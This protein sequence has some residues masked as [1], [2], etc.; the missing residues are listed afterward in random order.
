VHYRATI[1]KIS[2]SEGSWTTQLNALLEAIHYSFLKFCIYSFS[3]WYEF[4]VY[5]A[6]RV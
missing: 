3:L 4:L 6:L 2:R 1:K 5:Y